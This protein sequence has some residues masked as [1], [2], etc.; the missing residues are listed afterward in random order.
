MHYDR[1]VILRSALHLNMEK[2][3][4]NKFVFVLNFNIRA[5]VRIIMPQTLHDAVQKTLIT[6]EEPT[7]KQQGRTPERPT[8]QMMSGA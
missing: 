4:V 5:K 3:K 2:S 8:R 1:V 7:N 6:E